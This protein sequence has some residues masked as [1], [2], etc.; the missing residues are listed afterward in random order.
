MVLWKSTVLSL[1]PVEGEDYQDVV[2]AAAQL[3]WEGS[4]SRACTSIPIIDDKKIENDEYFF[5]IMG[6]IVAGAASPTLDH[7]PV[8]VMIM[9]NDGT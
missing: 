6:R 3:V 2:G 9:D 7:K 1:S 4:S 8:I 5:V